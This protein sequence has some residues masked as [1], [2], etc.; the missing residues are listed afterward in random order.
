MKYD[1]EELFLTISILGFAFL[2]IFGLLNIASDRDNDL[3]EWKAV[4]ANQSVHSKP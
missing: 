1:K 4:V 2:M 3:I